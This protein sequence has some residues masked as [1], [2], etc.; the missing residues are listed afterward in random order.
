M[1]K[2]RLRAL[3]EEMS[4]HDIDVYI[5]PTCDFH[6]SEYIGEYFKTR[7]FITGFTG[8]AGTAVITS[9]SAYLWTD[10]RYFLQAEEQL[11]DTEIILMKEGE[12]GVPSVIEFLQDNYSSVEVEETKSLKHHNHNNAVV[13][14]NGRMITISLAEEISSVCTVKSDVDLVDDIWDNRP[15][16]STKPLWILEEQYAGKTCIEKIRK[17]RKEIQRQNV[18]GLLVTALDEIAWTLNLRGN[19]VEHTPVFMA[20]MY[21]DINK[22]KLF[23]Q[24]SAINSEVASYLVNNDIEV[25]DYFSVYDYL[26]DCVNKKIW[27]D[28]K[29]ANYNILKALDGAEIFKCYTPIFNMKAIKNTVEIKNMK[30]AHI[31]DGVAMTKFIYW[32]KHTNE[33]LTEISVA[34]KLEE[35]RSLTA[36]YLE[37]S[38]API[39]GYM[40]HGAIVHYSATEDSSYKLEKEGIVLIDS[41]GQ[42]CFSD[43]NEYDLEDGNKYDLEN[44]D[45]YNLENV[46]VVG[47][48]KYCVGTTDITRTISLGDVTEEMKEMYTAVLKGHLSLMGA[49]FKEGC[50]GVSLDI[51]ARKPLWDKGL[52]YNHGTGHGVGYLLNVHE[53]PNAF[54]YKIL[55]DTN[56]NAVIM[57]GMITSNE[58]GVYLAGKFGIRIEN[59]ILCVK[60][61]NGFFGFESLTMVPYDK[62]LIN[63][64]QLSEEEK[65]ILDKYNQKVYRTL[66]SYLTDEEKV[67]L[68]N[69]FC[70]D[71]MKQEENFIT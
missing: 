34:E 10:G 60:K 39:V 38:F 12:E 22:V 46:E 35:F 47:E 49:T 44:I 21:V 70:V 27:L 25:E 11:K 40:D 14:F 45:E 31:L 4:R 54:R 9:D 67:W 26:K 57:P 8:S 63:M 15:V 29:T 52:D 59:L 66:K 62:E 42:Y 19:D 20:F 51:L 50:T 68:K 36:S 43:G 13:G 41:G 56:L 3:R 5:V 64:D 16:I 2:Q 33:E 65:H 32:L 48:Q 28:I 17:I 7:Q 61:Q 71:D 18:D 69:C 53:G 23:V 30:Q 1:I 37:P 24:R 58:P 55:S 6:G